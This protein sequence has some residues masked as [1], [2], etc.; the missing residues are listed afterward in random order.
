[1]GLVDEFV[2]CVCD[3]RQPQINLRWHRPT[4][5]AMNA[6]CESIAGGR[7]VRLAA[8]QASAK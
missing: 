5:E 3:G 2:A 6:S 8:A 7:P 1:M 4:M